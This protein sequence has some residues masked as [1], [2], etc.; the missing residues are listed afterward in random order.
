[1]ALLSGTTTVEVV[2]AATTATV[3]QADTTTAASCDDG[4]VGDDGRIVLSDDEI[5]TLIGTKKNQSSSTATAADTETRSVTANECSNTNDENDDYED[6]WDMLIPKPDPSIVGYPVSSKILLDRRKVDVVTTVRPEHSIGNDNPLGVSNYEW[7]KR[8]EL[9]VAYRALYLLGLG[10]DQAA[11]CL[12]LRLDEEE[13]YEANDDDESSITFLMAD[14]GIWFEEVTASNL[15]KFTTDGYLVENDGSKEPIH[16]V[17]ANIGCIPVAKAIF[18]SRHDINMIIHIH[19]YSVMSVSGTKYGLLPL[20]QASFFLWGQISREIYDFTYE[21]SF[22]SNLKAGFA[23]GERAMLLNHH[24]MYA[25][26]KDVAEATFVATHLTQACNVQIQTLSS[27]GGDLRKVI[28]P[29][30]EQLNIQY[31]DMMDSTDY[32]YDG[33]REW[34]GLVRKVQREASEYNT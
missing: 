31:K 11:Q 2:D 16:P 18:E 33:S 8:T 5:A 28:L 13:N 19:P 12:M 9:A 3:V 20:S 26:G 4:S 7:L 32:S 10:S 15:L 14:W 24:G 34:P 23:N 22:E 21:N 29:S 25:V 6:E 17:T 30:S 1:M 27:V